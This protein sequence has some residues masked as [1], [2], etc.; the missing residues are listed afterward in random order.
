MSRFISVDFPDR[1]L[2]ITYYGKSS[3]HEEVH[4]RGLPRPLVADYL[5]RKWMIERVFSVPLVAD[6]LVGNL[7]IE[8]VFKLMIY[9]VYN[10]YHYRRLLSYYY[11]GYS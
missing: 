9:Y 1:W 4:Q 2:P 7:K 11:P 6:Y 10:Y 8:R 5:L 3:I